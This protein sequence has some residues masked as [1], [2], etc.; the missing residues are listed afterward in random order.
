MPATLIWT[1]ALDGGD[2]RVE[3]THRDRFLQ[4]AAPFASAPEELMRVE[5]RAWGTNATADTNQIITYEYDRDRRWIRSL[6]HDLRAPG[7]EPRVLMDRSIRDRYGDPGS[8]V[9]VPDETGHAVVLQH[10]PWVY[11]AGMGASPE[12]NLPFLDRQNIETLETERIWRCETG[13]FEFAV[14]VMRTASDG[15]PSF[16]TQHQSPTDP[17]NYLLRSGDG[18]RANRS[19][20]FPIPRPKSARS[21]SSW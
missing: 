13:H 2:P 9:T 8:L 3:A 1:E 5:H 4:H 18:E 17:P 6:L 20:I 10:G 19:R 15:H 11:R 12:G 7:S 16:V 14:A 21:K